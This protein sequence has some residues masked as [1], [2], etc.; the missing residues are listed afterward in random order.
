MFS[1]FKKFIIPVIL[2]IGLVSGNQIRLPVKKFVNNPH[3]YFELSCASIGSATNMVCGL[4]PQ[5][6][7]SIQNYMNAQYYGDISVG[8]PAQ[9][10][11]VI[12]DTGSSNLW[13]PS[14]S[15]ST[16][17]DHK[18]YDHSKS[19]T[20]VSNG[21]DFEIRYGSG[22]VKGFVSE[23]TVN[24]GST[25][26]LKAIFA[27]VTDE[28]GKVFQRGKFD[29]ILGLAWKSISV[30]NIEPIF[31][32]MI[33]AKLVEQPVFSFY[34]TSTSG[35]DGEMLLGGI[36][37]TK[38]SGELFYVPL[39][40]ET[41]WEIDMNGFT[42]NGQEVISTKTAIVDTG[43]SLF[44]GPT[45]DIKKIASLVGATAS[46]LNPNEY[47]LSCDT[48]GSLPSI[49]I[50]LCNSDKQCKDF[51]LTAEDYVLQIS[52]FT[53]KICILGFTGIDVPPPRG[54]LFILG[55]PFI[56]KFYTVFDV[57]QERIGFAPVV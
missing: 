31:S 45:A 57:G 56:R 3:D 47:T 30:D 48:L 24:M 55:D 33:A 35:Q 1:L 39:S 40:S 11:S 25:A 27:E 8:T 37:Q 10:F 54:P 49:M 17:G 50:N 41:Y 38:Y 23:D 20:Y 19:S 43:T 21:T 51:E 18:K 32:Q 22:S 52:M 4:M 36:D 42:M 28:P 12:F 46:W 15:C 7:I 14:S 16:C 13:V 6:S 26:V 5:S 2:L 29:G 44:A 34:L 53:Q 9:I